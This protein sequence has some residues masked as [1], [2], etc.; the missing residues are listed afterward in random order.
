MGLERDGIVK[1]KTRI[2]AKG[3]IPWSGRSVWRAAWAQRRDETAEAK[4][5]DGWE[6][7]AAWDSR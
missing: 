6:L 5:D 1:W 3:F 7:V 4:R 2:V